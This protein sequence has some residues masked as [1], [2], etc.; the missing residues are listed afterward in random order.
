MRQH[1][2]KPVTLSSTPCLGEEQRILSN[3]L[4]K[5]MHLEILKLDLILH[6]NL[7]LLSP[8]FNCW[9]ILFLKMED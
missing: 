2:F 4:N 6:V 7:C 3:L 1:E 8:V 9:Y 5:L